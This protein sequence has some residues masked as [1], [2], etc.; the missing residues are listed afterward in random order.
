MKFLKGCI[1][2]PARKRM[3]ALMEMKTA[4]VTGV[5]L[6]ISLASTELRMY[7][8]RARL[9]CAHYLVM[10]S[11]TAFLKAL[12]CMLGRRVVSLGHRRRAL[13]CDAAAN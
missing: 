7:F 1:A 5:G 10:Q 12:C 9:G 11:Q 2:S 13:R 3:G 6:Q 4:G 8:S